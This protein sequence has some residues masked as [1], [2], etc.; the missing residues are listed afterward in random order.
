MVACV[1]SLVGGERGV[2]QL[3]R[4][5]GGARSQVDLQKVMTTVEAQGFN[6]QLP[7]G[8]MYVLRETLMPP[9]PLGAA[10]DAAVEGAPV[11][12][13]LLPGSLF[14][15]VPVPLSVRPLPSVQVPVRP[16]ARSLPALAP[17]CHRTCR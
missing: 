16:S 10:E 4:C 11:S 14:A 6:E 12:P 17:V 8:Y 13:T 5:H 3:V 1:F 9:P 15:Q 7:N 2:T